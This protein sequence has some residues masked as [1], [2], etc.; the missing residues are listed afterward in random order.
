M[1]PSILDVCHHQALGA[2]LRWQQCCHLKRRDQL[3]P[4][5]AKSKKRHTSPRFLLMCL[6]IIINTS[7]ALLLLMIDDSECGVFISG[8]EESA[9]IPNSGRQAFLP[10]HDGHFF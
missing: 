5:F 6:L 3:N 1:T 8:S 4:G 9:L 2:L 7:T 10:W